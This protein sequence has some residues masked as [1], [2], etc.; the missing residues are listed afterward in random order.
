MGIVILGVFIGY[1]VISL[2]ALVIV[3]KLASGKKWKWISGLMVVLTSILIPTWDIPIGRINFN[4]LC[5]TQAGQFIYKEVPLSEEY[6]LMTGERN[7]RYSNPLAESYYAK[8]G[9][10]NM[11][12]V[13]QDY[14]IDTT[15]DKKFSRWGYIYK[16]E[17]IVTRKNNNE[18]L[19]RAISFYYRSGWLFQGLMDGRAG[20]NACPKNALPGNNKYIHMTIVDNTFQ[21]EVH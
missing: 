19:S 1:V 5:E 11:E 10:I 17:T 13:K 15:F 3:V 20:Q 14:V 21:S 18:I 2:V 9:E 7:T 4:R 8:G 12:K 16:R 6:F